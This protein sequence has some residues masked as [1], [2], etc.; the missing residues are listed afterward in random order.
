VPDLHVFTVTYVRGGAQG[1]M[2]V[3]TDS[4]EITSAI[5][6]FE[7][8]HSLE[9]KTQIVGISYDTTIAVASP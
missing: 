4:P 2:V 8:N 6:V 1:A 3:G 9:S 7:E 5:P